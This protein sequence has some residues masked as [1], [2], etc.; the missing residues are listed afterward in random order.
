MRDVLWRGDFGR[1]GLGE[2]RRFLAGGG[3]VLDG[4]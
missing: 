2:L 4:F 3:M 1:F